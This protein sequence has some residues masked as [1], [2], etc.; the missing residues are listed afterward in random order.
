[1]RL[2]KLLLIPEKD[3]YPE[4]LP[5]LNRKNEKLSFLNLKKALKSQ[6]FKQATYMP[7]L[8]WMPMILSLANPLAIYGVHYI[9][10]HKLKDRQFESSVKYTLGLL[11]TLIW[12]G[13]LL[14]VST[15]LFGIDTAIWLTLGSIAL[16]IFRSDLKKL[17][18]PL[19]LTFVNED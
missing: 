8:R 19:D 7:V 3:D 16:L 4:H 9:M 17:T 14:G 5:G 13:L 2:I 1:M 11:L 18:D 15:W 6:T 12:W 10:T